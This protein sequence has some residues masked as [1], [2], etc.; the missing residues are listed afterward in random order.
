M[1][2]RQRKTRRGEMT[3][4]DWLAQPWPRSPQPS[5]LSCRDHPRWPSTSF[6]LVPAPLELRM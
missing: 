1:Q 5:G 3:I 2:N 4:W 6:D